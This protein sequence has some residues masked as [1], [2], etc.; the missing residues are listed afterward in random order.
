LPVQ[1]TDALPAALAFLSLLAYTTLRGEKLT[2]GDVPKIFEGDEPA[3]GPIDDAAAERLREVDTVLRRARLR[4][5]DYVDGI[6]Q[7]DASDPEVLDRYE[8]LRSLLEYVYGTPIA[9]TGETQRPKHPEKPAMLDP[10]DLTD[11]PSGR[12]WTIENRTNSAL[13]IVGVDRPPHVLPPLGSRTFEF[14]P[15]KAFDLVEYEATN[16][17]FVVERNQRETDAIWA[18]LGFVFLVFPVALVAFIVMLVGGHGDKAWY[19]WA[20]WGAFI[21]IC[22][23]V[24]WVARARDKERFREFRSDLPQML[25]ELLALVFVLTIG[26]AGTSAALYYGAD[27][28]Q[29]DGALVLTGRAIQFVFI[30]VASML[31]AL[32]YFLFDREHLGT[33]RGRFVHQ[34][35]RFDYTVGTIADV[36]AKYGATIDESYGVSTTGRRLRANRTPVIIATLVITLGW[37]LVILNPTV[38]AGSDLV[39]YLEPGKSAVA[40]GFLG[41]YF[42]ALFAVLRGYVR[43]DLQP[44][45]YT[46]ITV[47]VV[48]VVILAWL[49]EIAF[50]D[51]A[52]HLYVLAF[53]A[54]IVPE[55]ALLWLR[56]FA[57]RAMPDIVKGQQ[58]TDLE[59]IDLYD[60]AR[61]QSEGVTD[62]QA[63]AN[64][65]LIELM[66]RTRIP[67]TQLVDWTDQAILHLHVVDLPNRHG[68][69]E[70]ENP[71]SLDILRQYGIRTAT[72]LLAVWEA[73]G[74]PVCNDEKTAREK[75]DDPVDDGQSAARTSFLNILG[76]D[77]GKPKRLSVIL[78]AIDDEEWL[79]NL[80]YWHDPSYKPKNARVG[81]GGAVEE[82]K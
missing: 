71:G 14:D 26:L 67:I 49:L 73:F 47:R 38:K 66:L 44:K 63:L 34:I 21:L 42:F 12:S 60:R 1:T 16:K 62:I 51:D 24:I 46:D 2:D 74:H 22:L 72:D 40:F 4:V 33:L 30:A 9:F 45:F 18:L 10:E 70:R 79:E 23:L 3:L 53:L 29:D 11:D 39:A 57:G 48:V 77:E 52:A 7:I 27:V 61:L 80:R 31:P 76:G 32:L 43:R 59:G 55:Q 81:N 82:E 6:E 58:L 64:A 19:P 28:R 13:E 15:R 54:G 78:T 8:R 69:S 56:E 68:K 35:F 65:D 20:A 36:D 50:P 75:A 25:L 37:I 5:L 17:V 41:A